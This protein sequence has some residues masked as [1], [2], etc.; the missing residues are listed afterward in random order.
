MSAT[1]G[2]SASMFATSIRRRRILGR[3]FEWFC[4][5]TALAAV[6]VLAGLLANVLWQGWSCL[7]WNFL[8]NPPS[9]LWP[10]KAGVFPAL[11]GTLWLMALTV[12][13]AVPAGLGAAVYLE[14]YAR[15]SRFTR[16]IHLNIANLAGVPSIVY[17][18]LGLAVFVRWLVGSRSLLA[19]A[20]TL[21]LL[22]LPVIVIASREALLAVP[23]S[24]REAAYAV[25]ATRWQCIRA[26]V[27]PAALPGIMTGLILAVSRA[28]GE[29]APLIMLG[30]LTFVLAA[31][32]RWSS[33]YSATPAG[34]AHWLNDALH[35]PFTALPL[36]VYNWASQPD[37][38]FR[39][40]AA[41][42][43]VVL[44]VVLLTMNA[45]ATGIRAWQQRRRPW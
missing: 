45:L 2:A 4:L 6:A 42:G 8:T 15:P 3:V 25:G 19:G 34:L 28:I 43:I 11:V 16:L 32:G 37:D 39:Q 21:S 13:I 5:S 14:E 38:V 10:E 24:I 9:Q 41:A 17:G 12:V 20:L 31:P 27:L 29:T 40:L 7:R 35:S 36:Q 44:L 1:V 18:I 26:H 33:D 30:A 23:K 22:V